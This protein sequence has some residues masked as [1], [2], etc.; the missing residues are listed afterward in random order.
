MLWFASAQ[1]AN[2]GHWNIRVFVT[3]PYWL[4][5]ESSQQYQHSATNANPQTKRMCEK[6][7]H[8]S[9]RAHSWPSVLCY[10]EQLRFAC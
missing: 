7:M 5:L 2:V 4:D 9:H 6:Q 8:L 3:I 1:E 10:T